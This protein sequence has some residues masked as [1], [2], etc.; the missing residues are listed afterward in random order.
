MHK[1]S[2][3]PREPA[4]L[5]W[6]ILMQLPLLALAGLAIPLLCFGYAYLFPDPVAGE[7]IEKHLTSVAIAATAVTL[8]VWTAA[9][10][11]AIACAVVWIMKGPAY[12]AD[13]YPLSDADQPR[14]T[15]TRQDRSAEQ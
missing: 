12:T 5:E 9:F 3:S 6:R 4:G 14:A 8:T 1:S 2:R 10:T 15:S 11:L 7:S 13:S